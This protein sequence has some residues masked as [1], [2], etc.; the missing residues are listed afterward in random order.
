[1]FILFYLVCTRPHKHY[2]E[3]RNK[4]YLSVY[5]FSHPAFRPFWYLSNNPKMLPL[6]RGARPHNVNPS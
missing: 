3:F 5:S 1:M 6:V 4:G 2:P